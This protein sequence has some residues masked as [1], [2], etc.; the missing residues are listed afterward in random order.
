MKP[1][2]L[3]PDLTSWTDNRYISKFQT[4]DK[5]G[6]RQ[7]EISAREKKR[8]ENINKVGGEGFL[9]SWEGICSDLVLHV[10]KNS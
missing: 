9:G 8:G 7:D 3:A 5:V 2:F 6:C 4:K 1:T 10:L